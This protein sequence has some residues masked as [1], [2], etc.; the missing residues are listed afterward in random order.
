ML[1]S[2]HVD[3]EPDQVFPRRKAGLIQYLERI[4]CAALRVIRFIPE[5]RKSGHGNEAQPEITRIGGETRNSQLPVNIRARIFLKRAARYPVECQAQVVHPAGPENMRLI[6][7]Q[8][9]GPPWHQVSVARHGGKQPSRKGLKKVPVA[10]TEAARQGVVVAEGM[11]DARVKAIVPVPQSGCGDKILPHHRPVGFRK[12]IG[13]RGACRMLA[14]IRNHA[15]GEELAREWVERGQGARGKVSLAFFECGDIRNAGNSLSLASALVVNKEKRPVAPNRSTQGKTELVLLKLG[16]IRARVI[17]EIPGIQGGVAEKLINRAV[18]L[19]GA[20]L[21]DYVNLRSGTPP[22]RGV[23]GARLELELPNGIRRWGEREGIKHRVHVIDSVQQEVIGL[24]ASSVYVDRKVS[25]NRPGRTGG[26]GKG[27]RYQQA[28]LQKVPPVKRQIHDLVVFDNRLEPRV[29]H[30]GE[31]DIGQYRNLFGQGA[32]FEGEIQPCP[33]THAQPNP[34]TNKFFESSQFRLQPVSPRGHQHK[35][36]IPIHTCPREALQVGIEIEEGHL[37]PGKDCSGTIHHQTSK[38][39][40]YG[41]RT[42][43]KRCTCGNDQT[44][45]DPK[46][47]H[48]FAHITLLDRGRR[49]HSAS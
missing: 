10:E 32:N 45:D 6:Q 25:T 33:F 17:E 30:L 37:D 36:V 16:D 49:H 11:V 38:S 5:R 14:E 43:R 8:V 40:L 39:A 42:A 13:D 35:G 26:I 41:L 15:F 31:R 24:F 7:H 47:R 19:I 20:R 28:Q 46:T 23:V 22:E 18:K 1:S 48:V 4:R 34:A 44:Q 3:P 21:Q 27:A 9:L 12:K 29:L 2:S